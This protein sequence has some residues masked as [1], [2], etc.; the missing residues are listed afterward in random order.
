MKTHDLDLFNPR[1]ARNCRR[2][3]VSEVAGAITLAVLGVVLLVGMM[4]L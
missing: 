4:C 3:Y 2:S 1:L